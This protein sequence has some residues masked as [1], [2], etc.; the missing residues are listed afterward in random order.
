METGREYFPLLEADIITILRAVHIRN[1]RIII[2]GIEETAQQE[3]MGKG[4]TRDSSIAENFWNCFHPEARN[5]I[6]FGAAHCSNDQHW[7]YGRLMSQATPLLDARMLNVR[8]FGEHQSGAI[9]GFV[10]F[11]DEIGIKTEE[12]ALSDTGSL[13][14]WICA[15]FP[16]LRQQILEKFRAV[17]VFRP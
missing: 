15:K 4:R 8:I 17:V 6:L 7:L 12:F 3:K 2:R 1:P 11:L 10:F 16:T 9:E 5:V 14:P 13:D